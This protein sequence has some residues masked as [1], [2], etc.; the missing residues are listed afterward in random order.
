[1]CEK[2]KERLGRELKQRAK[3]KK[4]ANDNVRIKTVNGGTSIP[5]K[6]GIETFQPKPL[7][8]R[9]RKYNKFG[10][11]RSSVKIPRRSENK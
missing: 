6:K 2:V 1:M 4:H 5:N 9:K 11:N 3:Y 10:M 8:R 7:T